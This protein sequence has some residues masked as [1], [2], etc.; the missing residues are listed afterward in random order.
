MLSQRSSDGVFVRAYLRRADILHR[1]SDN[2]AKKHTRH[3]ACGQ[4]M[5]TIMFSEHRRPLRIGGFLSCDYTTL[6]RTILCA[7]R[8][9]GAPCDSGLCPWVSLVYLGEGDASG[10]VS[11]A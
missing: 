5:P 10:S 9:K 4:Q 1:H 8:H 3:Y 7:F 6:Y 2:Q 11:A